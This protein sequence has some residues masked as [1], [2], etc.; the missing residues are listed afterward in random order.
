MFKIFNLEGLF[1]SKAKKI[2]SMLLVLAMVLTVAPVSLTAFAAEGTYTEPKVSTV[3]FTVDTTATT[4]VIRVAAAAG[5]FSL[6]TAI[7]A[8]TPAGIPQN[9]GAYASVAYA[10]ETPTAPKV[11]FKITGATLSETPSLTTT[12]TSCQLADVQSSTSGNTTTYTWNIT[13]GVASAGTDVVFTIDYKVNGASY[14]AHA[15]SHVENILVMG[16]FLT[17]KKNDNSGDVA[18]HSVVTQL[19]SINMYSGMCQDS[20]VS[21]RKVG[22][23]NYAATAPD[24]GTNL[25]GMG[26]SDDLSTA[27]QAYASAAPNDAITGD[28]QGV[29]IKSRSESTGTQRNMCY[30][31]DTNKSENTVYIDKRKHKSL[32]DLKLKLVMQNGEE[33]DIGTIYAE[34]ATVYSGHKTFGDEEG[35]FTSDSAA[36]AI[37]T[38]SGTG[39]GNAITGSNV[40]GSVILP[41][42]GTGPTTV[43]DTEQQYSMIINIY[44]NNSGRTNRAAGGINL[45]FYVHDTTD[46]YSVYTGAQLGNGSTYST[47]LLTNSQSVT[48]NK[49]VN[50]QPG[51]YTAGW[52]NYESAMETAGKILVKPDAKQ[53]EI[54][55]ATANLISAYK[56]LSDVKGPQDVT[57]YHKAKYADGSILELGRQTGDPN[58]AN[59][60][61]TSVLADVPVGSTI[62]G[63]PATFTGYSI[64]DNSPQ[65]LNFKGNETGAIEMTFWYTPLTYNLNVYTNTDNDGDGNVDVITTKPE[66]G[67]T[68]KLNEL[69]YGTK[70]FYKFEGFYTDLALTQRASDFVMSNATVTLYVKWVPDDIDINVVMMVDGGAIG[71]KTYKVTP[72][73]SGTVDFDK[74]ST[75]DQPD[76]EGYLFAGFFEDAAC[77]VEAT[78]PRTYQLGSPD[79]TLYAK[80]VDVNGKIIFVSNGGSAVADI[81]FKGGDTVARPA[82]PT[83]TGYDFVNWYYDAECTEGNEVEWPVTLPDATGFIAYA[84][85]TAGQSTISFNIGGAITKYDTVEIA[86]ITGTVDTLIGT[87]YY[88]N[89]P[90]KF[91]YVF[92]GWTLNGVRYEFN[93]K[94]K[95]PTED[96]QLKA[97]W[98][99]VDTSAFADI[100]AYEKLSGSYVETD[101]AF[102]GDIVTFRMT[103]QTNFAVGSS[104]FVFMYDSNFFELVNEGTSAFTVNRDNEYIDGINA[105]INGVTD[106]SVL[107]WPEMDRTET[108][109]DGSS[110]YYKAMM[111]TIDPTITADDYYC[112]P[113]NDGT[114]LVEF[115]LKVKDDATGSGKVYM[116]NDWTRTEDNIMGT[117]FYG[118][119][120]STN[121][122]VAD[123][124]NNKVTPNLDAAYAVITVNETE[125]VKSTVT[126]NANGGAWADGTTSKTY[127][128]RAETE[129]AD[130]VRPELEGYHLSDTNAW[131]LA[132]SDEYW[133]EGYYA[134]ESQS[135]NEFF[136]Q[137]LP[138]EYTITYYVDGAVFATETATY[139]ELI[140]NQITAPSRTGYEV[141][142]WSLT[143]GG[144]VIDLATFKCPIDGAELYAIWGPR[145]DTPYTITINWTVLASGVART[146]VVEL[147]GTTD[148]IVVLCEEIP[149][150]AVEGVTYLTVADTLPATVGTNYIYDSSLNNHLPT[151]V[152]IAAEGTTNIDVYY[153][154]KD[155]TATYDAN[156]GAWANGDLTRNETVEFQSNLQGPAEAP[157]R[158]GYVFQHWSR[159]KTGAAYDF[160]S[161]FAANATLYAVWKVE[162]FEA[163]FDVNGGAWADGTT[164]VKVTEIE[165]GKTIT[166]PATPAKEGYIFKGWAT[167]PD[168]TEAED[169]GTMDSTEGKT[170]YAVYGL[171]E[172][173]VTYKV[174]G[175]VLY[176]ETYNMGNSVKIRDAET[177]V[178]YSFSGWMINGAAAADFSMPAEDVVI[179]GTFTVNKYEVI[180]DANGGYYGADAQATT[181]SVLIEYGAP[182]VPPASSE[183]PVRN[184][185]EFIG[186][187][188]AADSTDKVTN[189]GTLDVAENGAVKFYA[190]WNATTAA[191]TIN[192]YY[193]DVNGS[194]DAAELV[195]VER[196]G[197]VG[198]TADITAEFEDV[199]NPYNRSGFTFDK[200]GS[201][202]TGVITP[203][204]APLTLNVYYTRNQ[205]TAKFIN[206][207]DVTE[208]TDYYGAVIEAI[209]DPAAKEGYTFMGWQGY[210]EDVTMPAN[211]D[212]EFTAVWEANDYTTTW[213][214]DGETFA[215]TVY[216]YATEI[217]V[218]T[219]PSKTG[220][221]FAGWEGYTDGMTMPAR[222][223]TFTAQWTKNS[224]TITYRNGSETTT[225]SVPYGDVIVLPEAPTMEGHTF[226]GWDGYT[227]GM[228]MPARALQF[229]ANWTVNQYTITFDSNGGSAVESITA[230]F[231]A[232]VTAPAAPTKEGHTFAGWNAELPATMPAAN[233]AFTAQWTVNNY[234][235]TWDVDGVKTTDTVAYGA[236]I[237]EKAAPV[238]EGFT[239]DGWSGYTAGMTM[240]AGDVEFTAAW[241]R[242][243][244]N[245]TWIVDGETIETAT[246]AYEDVITAPNPTKAGYTF[247]GWTPA[248]PAIM[249]AADQTFT[250]SFNANTDTA[251]TVKTY[252]MDTEGNYGEPTVENKLGTTD[253]TVS[254]VPEVIEGFTT[255]DSLNKLET[256]VS[257]NDDDIIE[258]YYARNK[259]NVITNVDGIEDVAAEVYFDAIV[260]APAAPTKEGHTFAGWLGYTAGMKMP[261]ENVTLTADW[262]VNNYNV[263]WNVDGATTVETYAY[264]ATIVV[265]A[266][267]TKEG[268]TFA[269]WSPAVPATQGAADAEYVAQWTVN[270]YT[271]TWDVDGV[272]TVET[273]A[274]GAEINKKADP[275]KTGYTFAGWLGYTDGMTMPA[276]DVTIV[277]DWTINQYTVTYANT[278]D[279]VIDAVTAD[280]NTPIANVAD[281]VKEG[282]TFRE[283][284]WTN[285]EGTV[286]SKPANVPAYNVTA[287]AQWTINSYK[288][289]WFV[290]GELVSA[291]TY[292]FGEEI[293]APAAPTKAGYTFAGWEGYTEGMTVP[294]EN[295]EVTA[296]WTANTDTPYV[297]EVYTMNVDGTTY[298][299]ETVDGLTG[300]TATTAV[301]VVS[302]KTGFTV[303]A[304][305]TTNYDAENGTASAVIAADGSTVIKVYYTR[306]KYELTINVD[307]VETTETYFYGEEIA[308]PAAPENKEGHTFAGWE[309]Y[310]EGMT[311]NGEDITFTAQWTVNNYTVTWIIDG[312][313]NVETYAYGAAIVA[314][315][316]PEKEGY[317]TVAWLNEAG[318]LVNV[319]EKMPAT[320]LVYMAL[321]EANLYEIEYYVDGK[322]AATVSVEYDET[323]KPI[324]V[325][326]PVG[327]AFDRWYTDAEMTTELAADATV[328]GNAKIYGKFVS[329]KYNAT[330]IVDGEVYA[331]VETAFDEQIVAP[332]DPEIAGYEFKGWTPD[333]GI[334][335][336]EGKTFYANFAAKAGAYTIKYIVD[337]KEDIFEMAIG[338]EFEILAEPAKEGHTFAG[339][340]DAEGNAAV[341]PEYMDAK[342][343]EFTA[344]WTV[345]NYTVTWNVDGEITTATVA[346]G[347]EIVAPAAPT[348]EGYTFAGWEGYTEGMTMPANGVEFAATWTVNNYTVT[349]N[350]DGKTTVDTYAYGATIVVPEATKEGYTFTGWYVGDTRVDVP[351]TMPA[352]NLEFT[353]NFSKDAYTVTW[354]ID[355]TTKVETY[356]YGEVIVAPE[357]TK[358]GYTFT[359]WDGGYTEG[360]TMPAA[361]QTFTAQWSINT[362]TVTWDVDGV[363]TEE[364]YVY[365]EEIKAPAAPADKEGYTFAGWEGYTEG[366]TMP[367]DEKLTFTATWTV[368]NYTV[369]WIIDGVEETETYAYG[370]TIVAPEATKEGWSFVEWTPAVPATMPAEDLEFTAVFVQNTVTVTFYDYPETAEPYFDTEISDRTEVHA[371]QVYDAGATIVL[372]EA[373]TFKHYTF[374]GWIDADGNAYVEGATADS[375]M[376]YYAKYE[377]IAVTLVAV[378]GS[379]T[380]IERGANAEQSYIY[381]FTNKRALPTTANLV[382]DANTPSG[383]YITYTG[384]GSIEIV[385]REGMETQ[386]YLG[387]GTKV[388][389]KDNV[390][391][392]VVESFYLIYFGDVNG[393]CA[394]NAADYSM[395]NAE[396]VVGRTWSAA[397]G[398]Q[399]V[400]YM[401]KAANLDG[402]GTITAVDRTR[403]KNSI[404]ASIAINQS[405][406][407][408]E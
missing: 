390:T 22:Y 360:M 7:V 90:L 109:A 206:D 201:K 96:I 208:V 19:Q 395:V 245:V 402:V 289:E 89:E 359:G 383:R 122:S 388:I 179:E 180:F 139:N 194:Y 246:Y 367:A 121:D 327:F 216:S 257:V 50:P 123:T 33:S 303:N 268:Y 77:T 211:N 171:A 255:D 182:I 210:T 145:D 325:N 294:A 250:G 247:S 368:N 11:V 286:I 203:S 403:L 209:D 108:K 135:G 157:V 298:A 254:I 74:P 9:S 338:D 221:T 93:G 53:S 332:A 186:W 358:E 133:A 232:D 13:G 326:A 269:G 44:S 15:Y 202:L 140:P 287:T 223:L 401:I 207:G 339:W 300:T 18:R 69:D 380:V 98:T 369:T 46:L 291:D 199:N 318:K 159:T 351:A 132:D 236:A 1:L 222:D 279:T 381:G 404:S 166:A 152:T 187:A 244:Y 350:I 262:T 336:E 51:M 16:G 312:T 355:G 58:M 184:G 259:Y 340:V 373:P 95:F 304:A 40:Y 37:M 190:I 23:I 313:T 277:A 374:V 198:T 377:R 392:E 79:D 151:E 28:E 309:G 375:N 136:A 385:R 181:K 154:G 193:M 284:Q 103:T 316:V 82:D 364:T 315:T 83:R 306:E 99:A 283:W 195:E 372:P 43:S 57:I 4:E 36:S 172:Y 293:V 296:K 394:V 183:Q 331:V 288:I 396:L 55:T 94:N 231:G 290:D 110:A 102:A 170:F 352:E 256:I 341:F 175:E 376:A 345:N 60:V 349:W 12:L 126:I 353:A 214:V 162:T 101:S 239:F 230:D 324:T 219:A 75:A 242:N 105:K 70:E 144:E 397:R 329:T 48:F 227:E 29:L 393:D 320:N 382:K 147:T 150:P 285:A 280:Y 218:P 271:V 27:A 81:E 363:I 131:K 370:A 386:R 346:Y 354:N 319:P 112:A 234:T 39:S 63:Y 389:L 407:I 212:L 384:D 138:N 62:V 213:V 49:G 205:Y 2:I 100:A 59:A 270:N 148:S 275:A 119:S 273:Y 356:A 42:S 137:W 21:N 220:Y 61:Y 342:N 173:T 307:G 276:D 344:T 365:G 31:N 265:P 249:P 164:D 238:K 167:T 160:S 165:F 391:G 188:A 197:L 84:K 215:T 153:R 328:T 56:G 278:G 282:Y 115:K 337:G 310:T 52:S 302:D 267:P 35:S 347:A 281:P 87:D 124:Y 297:V 163:K 88:P 20:T 34:T 314:P 161:I 322:L 348:K 191:Y 67:S 317:R 263:T 217:R 66:F 408:A 311:M 129:I 127:E 141:K 406:G 361:N 241:T 174:D 54:D 229:N 45:D 111:I 251:Y 106:D 97:S 118:W 6:G 146:Q 85:W 228:T 92:N 308:A 30:N 321:Y 5:S 117:Q 399:R 258:V 334:M 78:W 295:L 371:E 260:S 185:Y 292:D 104:V 116:S 366:M 113:L 26:N 192:I 333:V 323:I 3:Q 155:V 176:T 128:G 177:K 107:P 226:A 405:T 204:D 378:D 143:E 225:Q 41:F 200:A 38:I 142:G 272:T 158:S 301:Y 14:Q 134:K 32:S 224:Y 335:D 24:E 80:M 387:T 243:N 362:Y 240:P 71:T 178:G 130:Y 17:Y 266:A 235:V 76:V 114:W 73:E 248:V 10:G 299:K 398:S 400:P 330:F 252:V 237:N 47:K 264:G 169:L 253:E 8:A 379:T 168:A 65:T 120:K 68:V 72:V 156:G 357:A 25:Y 86:P 149:S 274:Y 91:G 343:Y 125:P 261:A 189:Y 233:L 305:D 196:N 64:N